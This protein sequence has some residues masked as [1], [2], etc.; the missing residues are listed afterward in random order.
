METQMVTAEVYR[1]EMQ[2][3]TELT[4]GSESI[5]AEDAPAE[6]ARTSRG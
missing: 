2:I 4:T 1:E 5:G 3:H 6:W